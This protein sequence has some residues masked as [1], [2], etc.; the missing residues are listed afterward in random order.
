[1][2]YDERIRVLR[3]ELQTLTNQ[4]KAAYADLETKGEKATAD[5]RTAFLKLTED[6]KGK[7][8]EL[9]ALLELDSADALVNQPAGQA[10]VAGQAIA[11]QKPRKSWGRR[12][13][14]SDQFKTAT[15]EAG[16]RMATNQKQR[17]EPVNV[18]AP[19]Y[20]GTEATGGALLDAQRET[21]IIDLPFRPRSILDLVNISRTDSNVVEYVKVDTRTNN[22]APVAEYT[23]GNFGLKPESGITFDLLST[24]VRTIATWIPASR[25]ILRDAPNLQNIIDTQLTEMLRVVLEQQIV[26]GSGSGENFAGIINASGVLTR[27]RGTGARAAAGDSVADTIRRGITD[28]MLEF[29]TPNGILLNPTDTEEIELERGDDEHYV[30]IWDPTTGRLWRLPVYESPVI[31]ADKGVVG[32]WTMGATLWDRMET[33]IRVGEPND[34]FLRN[35]VAVLAELRAAFAVVRPKAFCVLTLTEPTP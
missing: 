15:A 20:E 12:V 27:T 33:E 13:V 11:S 10:K 29:Y 30:K 2:G 18:K 26:A 6:G 25:N 8:A 1:V 21:E 3:T 4:A 34:F 31:A 35:A 32:D 14:E 5:E 16:R 17:M 9:E 7:K 23:G 19:L 28:V 22:A 24:N